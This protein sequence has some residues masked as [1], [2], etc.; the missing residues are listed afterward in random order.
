MRE[1]RTAGSA[2]DAE[3]DT[4]DQFIDSTDVTCTSQSS[5]KTVQVCA[6]DVKGILYFVDAFQNVYKT[7]DVLN[8]MENP[9]IIG[10]AILKDDD[11]SEPVPYILDAPP[12]R[13]GTMILKEPQN[14]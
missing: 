8:Q 9:K 10:R 14:I 6:V 3:W 4:M 13:I 2:T 12:T 7:E 5:K 11:K 1:L